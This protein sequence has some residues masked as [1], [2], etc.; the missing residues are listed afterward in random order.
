ME[1]LEGTGYRVTVC[2]DGIKALALFK[3]HP[4]KFDLV[5]TDYSMPNITGK[6]LIGK[7][8]EVRPDIP[9]ILSSGYHDLIDENETEKLGVKQ[10]LMKPLKLKMLKE[11]IDRYVTSPV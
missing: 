5:L 8:L 4:G 2:E 11:T 3:D 1:Y 6:E 9:I 7:L 10:C